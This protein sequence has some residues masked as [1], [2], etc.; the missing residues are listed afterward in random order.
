MNKQTFGRI[1][2]ELAEQYLLGKGYKI[3]TVNFNAL[4]GEIDIIALKHGV[5][6]FCEVKTKSSM[7]RGAP[8]S[9]LSYTKEAALKRTARYFLKA[10]GYGGRVRVPFWFTSVRLPYKKYRF[11]LIELLVKDGKVKRLIH[12]KDII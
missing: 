9:Q 4:G 1:G 5:L 10:I 2:E 12:T 3:I 6:V 7:W 11:D 8:S